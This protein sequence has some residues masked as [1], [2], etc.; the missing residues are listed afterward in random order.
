MNFSDY[1]SK[2]PRI[3]KKIEIELIDK[4]E[5]LLT[6]LNQLRERGEALEREPGEFANSRF[7]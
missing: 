6:F 2:I 4:K 5:I 1:F 7:P 3:S